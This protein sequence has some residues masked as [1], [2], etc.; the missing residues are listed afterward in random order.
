MSTAETA[1]RL[2]FAFMVCGGAFMSLVFGIVASIWNKQ[3][4]KISA[5]TCWGMVAGTLGMLSF[6][7][8]MHLLIG[9]AIR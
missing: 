9:G 7:L 1:Y 2:I 6:L 5:M 4:D 3:G 8:F